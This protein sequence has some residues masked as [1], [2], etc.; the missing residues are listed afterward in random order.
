MS[1]FARLRLAQ[2]LRAA[3]GYLELGMAEHALRVLDEIEE[4]NSSQGSVDYLRGEAL[5]SLERYEDALVPLQRAV[6]RLPSKINIWIALGWCQKR[7][8][9]LDL[10]IE[11]LEKALTAEPT[12]E[13]RALLTYN[14]A[15]YT[16]LQGHTQRAV[17]LL[18]KACAIEPHY[19]ELALSESDFDRIRS[20]PGFQSVTSIIV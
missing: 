19:K 5:R 20:D 11:S 12:R 7:T 3:E 17:S 4:P 18:R 14:L 6:E 15:C 1:E 16:S 10:A 13:E 9:Q 2:R 8:G